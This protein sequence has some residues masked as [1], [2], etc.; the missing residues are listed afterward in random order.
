MTAF[1]QD[2]QVQDTSEGID[3]LTARVLVVGDDDAHRTALQFGLLRAGFAVKIVRDGA[4]A[5]KAVH[6]WNPDTIVLDVMLP[7]VNGFAALPMIRRL[8]EAPIIMLSSRH[9]ASEKIA[10]LMRG[11][12]DYVSRP[13]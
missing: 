8:T 7:K 6:E 13:V 1:K 10:A 4:S 9:S 2:R 11:A 3:N 5:L 12:D